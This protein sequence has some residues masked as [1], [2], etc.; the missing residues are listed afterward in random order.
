M[1][2]YKNWQEHILIFLVLLAPEL[3]ASENAKI[4]ITPQVLMINPLK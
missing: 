3:P 4:Q 1:H 2:F